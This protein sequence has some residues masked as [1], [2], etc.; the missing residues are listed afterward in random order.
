MNVEGSFPVLGIDAFHDPL[1]TVHHFQYH[2]LIGKRFIEK[3]HQHDFYIFL[4]VRQGSGIHCIDFTDYEVS[5]FQMHLLFPGQV[6]KWDFKKN[7]IAY[8]L[9]I[10]K[11]NF[12]MFSD[13]LAVSFVLFQNHPVIQL[14]KNSFQRL[15]TEFQALEQELKMKPIHWPIIYLLSRLIC[16]LVSRDVE[17]SVSDMTVFKT[18][19]QLRAYHLLVDQHF[20][21]HKS[22]AFYA[23]QLHLTANYLNIL[24]QKHFKV[25]ALSIIQKRISLEAKRLLNRSELS[26]K[27]IAY[28]LGFNDPAHFSHF[29]KEQI[30]LSPKDFRALI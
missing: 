22:V 12:E 11:R 8:Q 5:D 27:E 19:P 15:L 3:P 18:K 6:H 28:D 25:S 21:Q 9:M 24:C 20:K 13:S 29:F 16:E 1:Q 14:S 17:H 4:L 10:D 2:E 30:G 26:I 7:T 23:G